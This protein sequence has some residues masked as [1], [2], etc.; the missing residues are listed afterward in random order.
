MSGN[1]SNA[2]LWAQIALQ[3][4]N[5]EMLDACV[6][7]LSQN[8]DFVQQH[9]MTYKLSIGVTGLAWAM[10]FLA[11]QKI[12]TPADCESL[13]EID[14]YIIKSLDGNKLERVYDLLQGLIGKGVYLCERNTPAA[15]RALEDIVDY[16]EHTIVSPDKDQMGWMD[17]HTSYFDQTERDDL[18]YY[19]LGLAHGIPSIIV[20]LARLHKMGIKQ[21]QCAAL[22]RRGTDF[23]LENRVLD[24][25][26]FPYPSKLYPLNGQLIPNV[27]KITGWCYGPLSL[28][29]AF[30]AA[31][32]I[33]DDPSLFAEARDLTLN[34]V[35]MREEDI[36]RAG[37]NPKRMDVYLCHGTAGLAYLYHR[38]NRTF[39]N[40]K[41]TKAVEYWQALTYEKIQEQPAGFYKACGLLTGMTGVCLIMN[42]LD[43]ST[44]SEFQWDRLFLLDQL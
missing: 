38:L 39:Q 18:G 34:G 30:L 11:N 8:I 4:Q 31:N 25:P 5:E 21:K 2:L 33:L 19:N 22:I 12:L 23:L 9:T 29:I 42:D 10:Q 36:M 43:R 17:Y 6:N 24:D 13:D 35:D 37:N 14:G 41:L 16:F 40:P 27:S 15:R 26:I 1:L 28:A 20:F 44:P 3:E 32:D 7:V